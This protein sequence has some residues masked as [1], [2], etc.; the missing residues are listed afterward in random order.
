[1][2]HDFQYTIVRLQIQYFRVRSQTASTRFIYVLF[3]TAVTRIYFT[4]TVLNFQTTRIHT[5]FVSQ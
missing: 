2:L 4:T 1:M 3:K 5:N